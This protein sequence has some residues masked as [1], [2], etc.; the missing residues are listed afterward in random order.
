VEMSAGEPLISMKLFAVAKCSTWLVSKESPV[1][2]VPSLVILNSATVL[3]P[4]L[5]S[6]P[7][8][9]AHKVHKYTRVTRW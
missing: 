6:S 2:E 4:A 7:G 8:N 1:S 5:L 9:T 3:I